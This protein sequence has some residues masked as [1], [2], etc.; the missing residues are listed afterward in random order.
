MS[1]FQNLWKKLLQK[2]GYDTRP[3]IYLCGDRGRWGF[4]RAEDFEQEVKAMRRRTKH[5]KWSSDQG[6]WH[7]PAMPCVYPLFL[8][9]KDTGPDNHLVSGNLHEM[10][11]L[12]A[13]CRLEHRAFYLPEGDAHSVA[14]HEH[15]EFQ[16]VGREGSVMHRYDLETIMHMIGVDPKKLSHLIDARIEESIA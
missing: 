12:L 2:L 10:W 4:V 7:R 9:S 3:M 15:G 1:T 11:S 5:R 6:P 16:L 14:I 8:F 13:D